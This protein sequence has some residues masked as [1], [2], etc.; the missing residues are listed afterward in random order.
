MD[1]ESGRGVVAPEI[2]RDNQEGFAS[3]GVAPGFDW[4][5]GRQGRSVHAP[6]QDLALDAASGERDRG[7]LPRGGRAARDRRAALPARG[8]YR[9]VRARILRWPVESPDGKRLV[10]SAVRP[11][12]R[13]TCRRHARAADQR[14][15]LE[16]AP[17]FSR[18]R[19]VDRVRDLERREGGHVWVRRRAARRARDAGPA[20]YANPAFSPDG[21][22]SCS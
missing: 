4:T 8:G 20:Q 5:R 14:H 6:G 10:F 22:A 19:R 2:E 1:L 15:D 16:Y 13:G 3:H 9:Q 12:V 7:P 11:P 18:R 21:A 17:A